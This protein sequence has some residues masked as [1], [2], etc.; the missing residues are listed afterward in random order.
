MPLGR[1]IAA[2]MIDLDGTLLDTVPDIAAA[3]QRMLRALDLP[4]RTQQ[5]V[6]N[7]IGKGIPK[8]VE[9]CLQA[10]AGDARAGALQAEALALFEQFYFEESGRRSAVYPGVLEGLAR[11]RGLRLR[12]ACV[13]NKAARFTLPLL[14]QTGLAPWFE[15]VV[16]GDTL[17]RKKPDPMQL[18]HICAGF[19]LAPAQVVLIGDSANDAQAARAAGCPVMCVSYGYSEGGDVHDLD[20][21]AIVGSLSEA[22]NL[23]EG[24][25]GISGNSL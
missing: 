9:R 21:D 2:I 11:M 3:A 18:T 23:I 13:T 12:L 4:E 1:G 24:Q 15:L 8:L 20:C 19:A 6:R 25:F 10:S 7:Y 22:A 16:S 17:A 14:A 5:E